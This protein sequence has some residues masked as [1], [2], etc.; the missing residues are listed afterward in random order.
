MFYRVC[1]AA[2]VCLSVCHH[3]VAAPPQYSVTPLPTSGATAI[4]DH[5]HVVGTYL[6]ADGQ[7][8]AFLYRDGQLIDLGTL[9]GVNSRASG[10]N[11]LGDIVGYSETATESRRAFLYS[12]GVMRDLGIPLSSASAINNRRQIVGSANGVAFRLDDDTFTSL[13][14][15]GGSR[16]S[17]AAINDAGVIV[18]EAMTGASGDTVHH[19]FI[20]DGGVMSDLGTIDDGRSSYASDVNAHSEVVGISNTPDGLLV[21]F[22]YGMRRLPTLGGDYSYASAINDAGLI[23]GFADDEGGTERAALYID[24][25]PYD[26]NSLL[27]QDCVCDLSFADDINNAGQILASGWLNGDPRS[28]ILTPV[29]E[30]SLVSTLLLLMIVSLRRRTRFM[31]GWT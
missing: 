6:V 12:D 22:A 21:G 9:G 10:I 8:H 17:A 30:P 26:L 2:T 20:Y 19:A 13:G 4:N 1:I 14:T 27:D 3:A 29:P 11:D 31:V 15:L 5:G 16:S 18:G 25:I 23:V 7:S 28:F 24:R